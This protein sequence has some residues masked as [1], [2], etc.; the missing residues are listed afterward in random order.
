MNWLDRWTERST[1]A[2][3][4]GSGRRAFLTRLGTAVAGSTFMIPLLPVARGSEPATT[5]ADGTY[6]P[7]S[8]EYWRHCAIDGFACTCCGGSQTQ[9]PPGTELAAVTW[10]GTCNNPA[11]GRDYVISYN[12]CCGK[13]SC[14]RCLCNN[15][16]GERPMWMPP[17]SNDTNWCQGVKANSY[18]CTIAAVVG[19]ATGAS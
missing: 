6:D 1:R 2:V 15:N 5:S 4:Q 3:A 14:G 10:I 9:C 18:H 16:E 13:S 8:C 12:D 19:T 11:D 7:A 17:K